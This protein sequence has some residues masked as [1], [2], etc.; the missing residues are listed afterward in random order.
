MA[1]CQRHDLLASAEEERICA[2][3]ERVCMQLAEGGE[4]SIDF[5]LSAGLQ[6]KELYPFARAPSRASRIVGSAS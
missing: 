5:A 6:D 1:R 3:K 2:D 4:S